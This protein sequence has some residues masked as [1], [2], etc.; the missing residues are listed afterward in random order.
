M[1]DHGVNGI[2]LLGRVTSYLELY[3]GVPLKW[4]YFFTFQVYDLV[5]NLQLSSSVWILII[6]KTVK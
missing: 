3:A 1:C 5:I 2:V 6:D 4:I